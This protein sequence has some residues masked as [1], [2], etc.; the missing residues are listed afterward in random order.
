MVVMTMDIAVDAP[1]KVVLSWKDRLIGKGIVGSRKSINP[2]GL[3]DN[4][5]FEL[6][7]GDLTRSIV[8]RILSI[9]FSDRVHQLL[10]KDMD[11][12]MVLK[13][14]GQKIGY[15]ALKSSP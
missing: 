4:D 2:N 12:M 10:I 1:T 11:T 3:E 7:E 6:L 9:E 8:N 13:L 5:D 14:L 15:V